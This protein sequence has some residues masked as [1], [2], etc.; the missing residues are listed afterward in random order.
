MS[1]ADY[2]EHQ[3]L[4]WCVGRTPTPIVAYVAL[5]TAAPS[6]SGGG[7]EV[8]GASYARVAT[9]T[10]DWGTPTGGSV[11]N[12]AAIVFPTASGAYP[13]TVTHFGILDAATSG[14]LIRWAALTTPR[15][16]AS[17][18]TPGSRPVRWCSRRTKWRPTSA[19]C[20]RISRAT[21]RVPRLGVR[22]RGAIRRDRARPG[23]R[24]G[25]DQLA[26]QRGAASANTF[27]GYEIWRFNDAF[28]ATKPVFIKIEY[29]VAAVVDRPSLR[30]TASSATN[31]AGTPS[32]QMSALR[33]RSNPIRPRP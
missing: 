23:R 7:T 29:G 30:V 1:K 14:N 4:D 15:T 21:R 10:S 22:A 24:H 2:A 26:Q 11:A 18:E 13:A 27:A 3:T 16:V 5:Y 33:R 32:G 28:Q 31:G 9:L 19:T 25:P 6:D 17:G 20:R 12:T 8:T